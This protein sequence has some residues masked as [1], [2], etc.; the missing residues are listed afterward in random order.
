LINNRWGAIIG[1][2]L[3]GMFVGHMVKTYGRGN[4]LLFGVMGALFAALA[5]GMGDLWV[6][7]FAASRQTGVS[8]IAAFTVLVGNSNR[9]FSILFQA[10]TNEQLIVFTLLAIGEGFWIPFRVTYRPRKPRTA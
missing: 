4:S 3:I 10:L 2:L 1:S 7:V 8:P 5:L 9:L 6:I